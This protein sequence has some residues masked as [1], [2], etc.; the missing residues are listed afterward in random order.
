MLTDV[1]TV[2]FSSFKIHIKYPC[3]VD[4]GLKY[5]NSYKELIYS[6]GNRK[7]SFRMLK[8][9]TETFAYRCFDALEYV[10]YKGCLFVSYIYVASKSRNFFI[11]QDFPPLS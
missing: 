4:K 8:Y 2:I 9:L 3:L 5:F 6:N 1:K 11:R 10:H 7:K